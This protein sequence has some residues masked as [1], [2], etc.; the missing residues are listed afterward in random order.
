MKSVYVF[1]FFL[2]NFILAE[3]KNF[4]KKIVSIQNIRTK[5]IRPNEREL[6]S[7][8]VFQNTLVVYGGKSSDFE[9]LNDIQIYSFSNGY[10]RAP[11]ISNQG[12]LKRPGLSGHTMNLYQ[13]KFYIYGGRLSPFKLNEEVFVF[14][15]ENGVELFTTLKTTNEPVEKGRNGHSAVVY[16]DKL[17]VF[18]G[19]IRQDGKFKVTNDFYELNLKSNEWRRLNLTGDV[20]PPVQG[21]KVVVGDKKMY[22]FGGASTINN[23]SSFIYVINLEDYTS[24]KLIKFK[25][26]AYFGL[27]QINEKVYIFG[28]FN[29]HSKLTDLKVLNNF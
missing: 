26:R 18:G 22:V 11:T 15:L 21:H 4:F 1:I 29:Q 14:D 19:S 24:K 25:P 7:C 9:W 16:E 2:I 12:I 6:H 13:K 28:G 23:Y 5:G 8:G 10:W 20:P 27:S 17:L 3:C